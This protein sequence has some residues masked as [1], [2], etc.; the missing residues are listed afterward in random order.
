[1][2]LH[3]YTFSL[4]LFWNA[5]LLLTSQ[6]KNNQC[7]NADD[8]SKTLPKQPGYN[9]NTVVYTVLLA[10]YIYVAVIYVVNG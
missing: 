9:Y 6:K 1:M 3:D 2:I 7:T 5:R 8:S 4:V 10:M